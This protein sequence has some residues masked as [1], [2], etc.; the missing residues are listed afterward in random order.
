MEIR[1]QS[2]DVENLLITSNMGDRNFMIGNSIARFT[3]TIDGIEMKGEMIVNQEI[4][5][6]MKA[7]EE[8]IAASIKNA[9]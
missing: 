2:I 3:V 8:R 5:E 7:I 9:S 1:I 4:K 6:A